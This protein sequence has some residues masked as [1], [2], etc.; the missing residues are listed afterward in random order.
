[1]PKVL[2]VEGR[3]VF[4]QNR[5][6]RQSFRWLIHLGLLVSVSVSLV[7][8]A[9]LTIH[10][11]VGLLFV[12]LVGAHLMQRRQIS[13]RLVK[14]L[15]RWQTLHL[16]PGRLALSDAFLTVV[17]LVML[18]SGFWDYLAGRSSIRWHA[19]SG[20]LLVVLVVT[21]TARRWKRMRRSLV[22]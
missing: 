10:I 19:L 1:M 7:F 12:G 3:K 20:I 9:I 13:A 16:R 17:T 18:I 15:A 2:T 11:V 14:K 21:H 22:R 4:D 6:R 8:E 5:Q